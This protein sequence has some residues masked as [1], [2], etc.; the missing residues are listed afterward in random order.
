MRVGR[1]RGVE[2][3]QLSVRSLHEAVS[4]ETS[5]DAHRAIGISRPSC[6]AGYR[7]RFI[8]NQ[9]LAKSGNQTPPPLPIASL[10]PAL[11]YADASG[12]PCGILSALRGGTPGTRLVHRTGVAPRVPAGAHHR[13]QIQHRL[14]PPPTTATR[15]VRISQG[16]RLTDRQRPALPPGQ[17]TPNV[18]VDN[19]DIVLVRE[20]QHR[21]R[22]IRPD[23][24]ERLE[25]RAVRRHDAIVALHDLRAGA[26]QRCC[27]TV[28]AQPCPR[29]DHRRL[30]REV[31][32]SGSREF[33][34]QRCPSLNGARHLRLL[35]HDL[36]DQH[37]PGVSRLT[38]RQVAAVVP[39]PASKCATTA[40]CLRV[41]GAG[42]H[43]AS[44]LDFEDALF[45]GEAAGRRVL[46][47]PDHDPP[48][49]VADLFFALVDALGL[50]RHDATLAV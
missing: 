13:T 41:T 25:Q 28:V 8:A 35:Q 36:S 45:V 14:V 43:G 27:S 33:V 24:I 32:R 17:H 39:E 37:L 50:H 21:T 20:R 40:R 10:E 5:Q 11:A 46:P 19:T 2:E 18:R 47:L 38:P 7:V 30:P 42:R 23:A 12:A 22:R 48:S 15:N 31:Y 3:V 9:A 29:L 26:V 49:E 1:L 6:C 34:E 4:N 16:L 44:A